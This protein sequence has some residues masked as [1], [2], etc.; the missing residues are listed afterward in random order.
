MLL[1]RACTGLNAC[2]VTFH[3]VAVHRRLSEVGA[4]CARWHG[5]HMARPSCIATRAELSLRGIT[6][7]AL[8]AKLRAGEWQRVFPRVY[9]LHSGTLSSDERLVAALAYCGRGAALSHETAARL[10]RLGHTTRSNT[11][12]VT[13]PFARRLTAQ[14]GLALHYS[15]RW[16]EEDVTRV[17]GF[18][19]TSAPRTVLDLVAKARTPGDAACVVVDAVGSR[20][21]TSERIRDLAH[22][23]SGFRH[24]AVVLEVV[25][26]AEGG[27][28]SPLE[29]RHARACR[30]HALPV[31][32]RQAR[33]MLRGRVVYHDELLRPVAIVAEFDGRAGHSTAED[34]FRDMTRD[35]ANSVR[36]RSVLR[37]GWKNVLDEP[38]LV[39]ADRLQLLRL[40]GWQGPVRPCGPGCALDC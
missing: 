39:M 36:G 26:E 32:E 7:S 40:K 6:R 9:A 31:G 1:A 33:E 27:A 23:W 3:S 2:Q 19:C 5:R 20:R 37:L 16:T 25:T 30:R 14:K 38:C 8:E 18:E 12:H 4:A 29:L 10:H 28:H 17:R 24:R 34:V 11:I 35:N 13:V 22:S 15:R 21:T